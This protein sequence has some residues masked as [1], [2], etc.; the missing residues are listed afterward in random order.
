VFV[1]VFHP[2]LSAVSVAKISKASS[3]RRGLYF[4]GSSACFNRASALREAALTLPLLLP[5]RE[6]VGM[7]SLLR[8]LRSRHSYILVQQ[9]EG[10]TVSITF[11][12]AT[13]TPAIPTWAHENPVRP[14][15]GA[16]AR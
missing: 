1:W 6:K 16:H 10:E 11:D 7:R 12:I 4:F 13:L 8:I 5:L 3:V 9:V 2:R 14:F 15:A